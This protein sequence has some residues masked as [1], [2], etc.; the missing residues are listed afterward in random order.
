MSSSRGRIQ[1]AKAGAFVD[2]ERQ[3]QGAYFSAGFGHSIGYGGSACRLQPADKYLNLAPSIRDVAARYFGQKRIAWHK[4]ANH[5][6]S[7]QICCL[8][9]MMPF[10]EKPRALSTIIGAA[11]GMH[12]PEL[13]AVEHGPDGRPWFVAFEWNGA[14]DY[15]NE[16]SK[17]GQRTRGANSTSADAFVRFRHNGRVEGLLLEWKYT[18]AYG[19]PISAKGNTKRVKRYSET[20]FTPHGPIR[21][22]LGLKLEDFFYEP[23]YQLIRQQMLAFQMG[24]AREDGMDRVRVLHISPAANHA[25]RKVTSPTLRRFGDDAFATFQ[26]VLS[27]PEDFASRTTESLFGSVRKIIGEPAWAEYLFGRYRF[28]EDAQVASLDER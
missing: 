19:A 26:S 22:D 3:R 15:L 11:L 27:Q 23:F 9:F 12:E 4:H 18:E 10:A 1:K 24:K 21:S 2:R 16:A 14:T 28:L 13:L 7:S 25:L 8:N 5:G 17:D 20:A 6:L